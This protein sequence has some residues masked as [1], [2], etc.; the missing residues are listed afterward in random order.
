MKRETKTQNIVRTLD[1][2]HAI[3]IHK[4]QEFST[5]IILS[6]NVILYGAQLS[7]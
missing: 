4:F 6:M 7:T 3:V 5:F 1:N 2:K